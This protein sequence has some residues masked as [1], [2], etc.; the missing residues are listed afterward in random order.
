MK[1]DYPNGF[2]LKYAQKKGRMNPGSNI[3]IHGKAVSI[4][5]PAM[6]DISIEEL[7]TMVYKVGKSN[8]E[9]IISPTDARTK[10]LVPPSNSPEWISELYLLIE[11]RVILLT[12]T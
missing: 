7:F 1:L 2:D 4:G 5:C 8:V 11:E 6:G 9:V 10:K 3:F 12:E